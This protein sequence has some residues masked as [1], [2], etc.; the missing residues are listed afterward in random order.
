[1]S[2]AWREEI[3]VSQLVAQNVLQ[4]VCNTASL[5]MQ[6]SSS[7]GLKGRPLIQ[8]Q[9]QAVM[10]LIA[11]VASNSVPLDLVLTDA[12]QFT[13]YRFRDENL[14]NYENL[15]PK[16]VGTANFMTLHNVELCAVLCP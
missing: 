11:A 8:S 5:P 16:Q 3:L 15:S 13:I 4:N 2:R 1:V 14:L 6:G 9:P 12:R 10:A 7:E